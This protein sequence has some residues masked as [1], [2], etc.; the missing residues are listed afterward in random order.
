MKP[1]SSGLL[2]DY[3]LHLLLC[4]NQAFSIELGLAV[5]LSKCWDGD[6]GVT[7]CH[8]IIPAAGVPG[9]EAA[10]AGDEQQ[11]LW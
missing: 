9:A 8:S 3:L 2:S 11:S 10:G 7:C 4:E 5:L 1:L 6:L